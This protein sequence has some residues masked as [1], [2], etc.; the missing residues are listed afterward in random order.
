MARTYLYG[1]FSGGKWGLATNGRRLLRMIRECYRREDPRLAGEVQVYRLPW[2][3]GAPYSWD[4]P[5]F[6]A[7][8]DYWRTVRA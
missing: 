3:A 2:Y 4:A 5:T 1:W 8:A 7:V 6:R